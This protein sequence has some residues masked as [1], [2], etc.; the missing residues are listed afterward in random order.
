MYAS[1]AEIKT[2]FVD[3][4]KKYVLQKFIKTSHRV[5]MAQWSEEDGKWDVQVEDLATG[6][7]V[8]NSCHILIHACGYLNKPAWPTIP[9]IGDFKGIMLH[10]AGYDETISLEGK[11]VILIGNGSASCLFPLVRSSLSTTTIAN[12]CSSSAAQI[13]PAIQPFVKGVKIFVRSP[14]WLLP[15]ISSEQRGFTSEEIEKFVQDPTATLKLRKLNESTMNSIFSMH[16][17]SGM[18]RGEADE[19][20]AF[21][22]ETLSCK[23]NARN[24]SSQR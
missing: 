10:S 1:S 23:R 15:D 5:Q 18:P 19:A 8:Q 16:M 6:K 7:A 22:F 12:W 17:M 11:E 4:A 3:F 9:G 2:Y 14:L 24:S 20:Q 21:I 13:L